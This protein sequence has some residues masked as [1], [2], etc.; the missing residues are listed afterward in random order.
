[1]EAYCMKCRAKKE[2][3]D[4]KAVK[5]KNGKSAAILTHELQVAFFYNFAGII[6]VL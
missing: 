4:A 3:K 5:M 2:M 6:T 1:M